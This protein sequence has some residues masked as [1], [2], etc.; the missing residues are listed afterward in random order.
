[1]VPELTELSLGSVSPTGDVALGGADTAIM[2]AE[3][4]LRRSRCLLAYLKLGVT[5]PG[6]QRATVLGPMLDAAGASLTSLTFCIYQL[7]VSNLPL[8]TLPTRSWS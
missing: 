2:A 7:Q 5:A 3:R 8:P 1:M 6:L 4:M